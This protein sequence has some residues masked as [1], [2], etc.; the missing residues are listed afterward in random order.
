MIIKIL[1]ISSFLLKQKIKNPT[2]PKRKVGF[3]NLLTIPSPEQR[4]RQ[5]VTF[6]RKGSPN[7]NLR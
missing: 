1:F 5:K 4:D 6:N 3:Q 7:M 2:P